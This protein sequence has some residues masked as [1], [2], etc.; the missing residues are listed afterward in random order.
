MSRRIV[1]RIAVRGT[2]L[3]GCPGLAITRDADG[4]SFY[5]I[6]HIASGR[7]ILVRLSRAQARCR[8]RDLVATG[9]DWTLDDPAPLVTPA[10]HAELDA[11]QVC[12]AGWS[13]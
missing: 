1:V 10:L 5:S 7:Q 12:A 3:D 4:G 6:T 11:W 9:V 8:V 2:V 13:L